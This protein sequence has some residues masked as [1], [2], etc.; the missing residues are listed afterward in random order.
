MASEHDGGRWRLGA[1]VRSGPVVGV[2]ARNEGDEVTVFDPGDRRRQD[3]ATATVSPVPST[4]VRVTVTVDLPLAHG[5]DEADLRRWVAMLVDPVLRE[6][7]AAALRE[8]GLDDGVTLP[9]ADV[10]ASVLRD[11]LARCLCGTTSPARPGVAPAACAV[12]G[13]QPA[14]PAEA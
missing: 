6:R 14:P 10:V 3:A 12:C 4:A 7:A 2:V 9:A 11:G 5:L 8:A 1:W 13:R